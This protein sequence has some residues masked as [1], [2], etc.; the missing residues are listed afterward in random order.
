MNRLNKI[1][2]RVCVRLDKKIKTSISLLAKKN[3]E[4][5]GKI[6]RLIEEALT[7]YLYSLNDIDWDNFEE[8]ESYAEVINELVVSEN[9]MNLAEPSQLFFEYHTVSKLARYE[10]LIKSTHPCI[11]DVRTALI[12][13]SVSTYLSRE[14][15]LFQSLFVV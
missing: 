11:R 13:Q 8:D 3:Y 6:S 10:F 5:R 12:R 14:T 7:C 15:D 1:K 2:Q 9:Q 4:G